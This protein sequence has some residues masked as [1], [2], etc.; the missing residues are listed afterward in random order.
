MKLNH[1]KAPGELQVKILEKTL[2]NMGLVRPFGN[3]P[4]LAVG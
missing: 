3:G 4:K 1:Y 2:A